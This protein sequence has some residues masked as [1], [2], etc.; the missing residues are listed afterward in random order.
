MAAFTFR[1]GHL[2]KKPDYEVGDLVTE[3]NCIGRMGN[4]GQSKFNHVHSDCIHGYVKEIIRLS[5][6]GDDKEYKPS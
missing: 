3:G 5:E 2:E 1:V 4:T 6:I